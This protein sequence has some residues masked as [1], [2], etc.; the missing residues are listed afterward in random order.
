MKDFKLATQKH[1]NNRFESSDNK[2]Y[3]NSRTCEKDFL[4]GINYLLD[5][6]YKS[7]EEVKKLIHKEKS[8]T[9]SYIYD[10]MQDKW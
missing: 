6:G 9:A 2:Q 5:L 4:A 1:I 7:P 8:E 10:F 3:F